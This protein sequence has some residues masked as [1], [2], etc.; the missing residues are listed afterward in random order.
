MRT[1]SICNIDKA[2][3]DPNMK[4]EEIFKISTIAMR[5]NRCHPHIARDRFWVS[6]FSFIIILTLVCFVLLVNSILFH[7]I[8]G[9]KYTDATKNCIMVIVSVTNSFKYITLLYCQESVVKLIQIMDQDYETS[10]R[11]GADEKK[12]VL[13]Y[14]KRGAKGCKLWLIF[15]TAT[16]GIFPVNALVLMASYYY[17]NGELKL[18]PMFDFTYPSVIDEYK[19]VPWIFCCL[20]MLCLIFAAY[21]T[22]VFVGFDPLVPIFI[23][24]TCGQLE[25]VS[26]DIL[27]IYDEKKEDDIIVNLRKAI[28]K[29]QDIYRY[30]PSIFHKLN[31]HDYTNSAV[32]SLSLVRGLLRRL[33]NAPKVR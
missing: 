33:E 16:S 7:D 5:I 19:M 23:L 8:P 12:V 1:V 15:A 3:S 17:K 11:G 6:Q 32:Y 4:F 26:R 18:I 30:L 20:F 28:L 22:T 25:L 31:N 10:E 24:H 21:A 9:R 2:L 29:L 14:S 27:K 13:E